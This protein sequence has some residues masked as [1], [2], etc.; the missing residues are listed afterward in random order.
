MEKI[1]RSGYAAMKDM[2]DKLSCKFRKLQVLCT[3]LLDVSYSSRCDIDSG[4]QKYLK[5]RCSDS[6]SDL[7][8]MTSLETEYSEAMIGIGECK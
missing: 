1:D 7:G 2:N 8:S 4:I 3:H 6:R 5:K